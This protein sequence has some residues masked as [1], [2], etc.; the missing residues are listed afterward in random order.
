MLIPNIN[1]KQPL[2]GT[3]GYRPLRLYVTVRPPISIYLSIYVIVR[4][5]EFVRLCVN[6]NYFL[7]SAD[8]GNTKR[9]FRG[10]D[11]SVL[12]K[13]IVAFVGALTGYGTPLL[14]ADCLKFL[15]QR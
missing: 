7:A 11:T 12:N 3:I 6:K 14:I 2:F 9:V 1:Y 15:C 5:F 10:V 8:D 13:N 4:V